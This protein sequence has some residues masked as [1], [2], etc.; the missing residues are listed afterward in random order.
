[1][2]KEFRHCNWPT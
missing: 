2:A 1:M